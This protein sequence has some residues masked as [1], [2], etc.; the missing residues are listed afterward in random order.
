QVADGHGDDFIA[1][2]RD[3][4]GG[5]RELQE[6]TRQGQTGSPGDLLK[7]SYAQIFF[8]EAASTP[9]Q[10][11]IVGANTAVLKLPAPLLQTSVFGTRSAIATGDLNG[12]GIDDLI[13]AVGQDSTLNYPPSGKAGVYILFGSETRWSGEVDVM[14]DAD[15]VIRGPKGLPLIATERAQ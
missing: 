3:Y 6:W 14:N 5:L 15:V 11:Y 10:T 1:A 2:V 13:V 4:T 9:Q 8:G 12:D 7:A